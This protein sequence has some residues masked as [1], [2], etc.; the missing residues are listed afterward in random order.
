[1]KKIAPL[2]FALAFVLLGSVN[3]AHASVVCNSPDHSIWNSS[4]DTKVG[5]IT[6]VDWKASLAK[7]VT[8]DADI[9]FVPSGQS[10]RLAWGYVDTCPTYI[11]QGCVINKN[12]LAK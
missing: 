12:L 11:R 10:V 3:F 7:Q 2:F 4:N 5:C 8:T 1:M 9:I 6:D